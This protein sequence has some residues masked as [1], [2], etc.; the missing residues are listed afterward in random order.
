LISNARP[1]HRLLIANP[2]PLP[3]TE[4]A[5]SNGVIHHEDEVEHVSR[6]RGVSQVVAYAAWRDECDGQERIRYLGD[7]TFFS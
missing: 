7:I 3:S 5:R 4:G 6:F 1:T 2:P